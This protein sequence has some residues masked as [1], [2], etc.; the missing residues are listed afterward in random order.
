MT[1]QGARVPDPGGSR[2]KRVQ[3]RCRFR[4]TETLD[5]RVVA[6]QIMQLRSLRPE[7]LESER[8]PGKLYRLCA[9]QG[10][11]RAMQNVCVSA[12]TRDSRVAEELD[13]GVVYL[14]SRKWPVRC[15]TSTSQFCCVLC[16]CEGDECT[17]LAIRHSCVPRPWRCLS[18]WQETKGTSVPEKVQVF[19]T[20]CGER[21]R[22]GRVYI[23]R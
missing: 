22:Y 9:T 16:L 13:P 5:V 19:C 20:S 14:M 12:N 11:P 1:V 15:N 2:C 7:S 17:N 10:L 21:R 18:R 6:K 4:E 23:E 8:N 3:E